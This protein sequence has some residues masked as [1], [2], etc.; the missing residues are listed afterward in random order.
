MIEHGGELRTIELAVLIGDEDL[1]LAVPC[2]GVLQ[3]PASVD[4]PL[5]G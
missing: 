2:Q 1:G 3:S 4:R 5:Y